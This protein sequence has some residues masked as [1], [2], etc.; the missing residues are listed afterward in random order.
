MAGGGGDVPTSLEEAI[1]V[2]KDFAL[3]YDVDLQREPHLLPIIQVSH[4]QQHAHFNLQFA[5][6]RRAIPPWLFLISR[7]TACFVCP[8]QEASAASLPDG[9]DEVCPAL[10]P[11]AL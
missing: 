7:E 8:C 9:W 3:F 2:F 11:A 10:S 6:W 1:A 4:W 5:A